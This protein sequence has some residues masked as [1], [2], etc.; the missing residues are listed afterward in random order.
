ML[1]FPLD[2]LMDYDKC[3]NFLS[4][5]FHEKGFCCPLGHALPK[6]Q[7]PHYK[8]KNG[9]PCFLCRKCK[10]TFNIFTNTILKGAHYDCVKIVLILQGIAQGKTT[11]HLSKELS[12]GYNG[13][14]KLRHKV[15][16][17]SYENRLYTQMEDGEVESDEV[18]INAGEKGHKHDDPADPARVRAN[19]KKA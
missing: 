5:I 10:K 4:T 13:L 16:E 6:D 14:L 9:M 18:F 17:L 15:Q 19:K 3:Y 7:S 11:Q 1:Q 8:R 2:N 12:L